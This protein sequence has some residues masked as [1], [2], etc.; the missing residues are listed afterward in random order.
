MNGKAQKGSIFKD[1]KRQQ[2][3]YSSKDKCCG[4]SACAMA[5]PKQCITMVA[6]EEGFY[7][8]QINQELCIHC[9]KCL[10]VCPITKEGTNVSDDIHCYAAYSLNEDIRKISSSGG[11]FSELARDV[12]SSG[13]L[14][15]GA[16]FSKEFKVE[17]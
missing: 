4:C 12:I 5:C 9:N 3:I 1:I 10:Q 15:Y 17:T 16:G 8:P 14:V 11:I 6:D 13:G 2:V 7:N